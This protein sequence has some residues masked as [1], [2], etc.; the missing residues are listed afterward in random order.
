MEKE[1]TSI[2]PLLG[3]IVTAIKELKKEE[4]TKLKAKQRTEE[5]D[6]IILAD[7]PRDKAEE[8]Q[9]KMEKKE[10]KVEIVETK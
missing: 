5:G 7:V 1:G 3:D 8:F 9:K 4:V 10:A 6:K 2:I